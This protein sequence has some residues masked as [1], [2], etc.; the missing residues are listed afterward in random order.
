M[1]IFSSLL[2]RTCLLTSGLIVASTVNLAAQATG[3]EGYFGLHNDTGNNIL[4][5][6]YTN[7]GSGWSDNW[8]DEDLAPGNSITV[9]FIADTGACAQSLRAGWLGSDQESEILDEPFNIDICDT[10]N[11]YLR[12]NDIVYD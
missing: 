1:R 9:E 12:D 6:F 4:I 11:V 2:L 10:N 3:S 8:L 7:D 5:G